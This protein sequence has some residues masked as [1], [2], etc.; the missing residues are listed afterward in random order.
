MQVTVTTVIRHL[1]ALLTEKMDEVVSLSN[2]RWYR[3]ERYNTRDQNQKRT[4]PH[5]AFSSVRQNIVFFFT[6]QCN[7]TTTTT[8]ANQ[9]SSVLSYHTSKYPPTSSSKSP[10]PPPSGYPSY[11]PL[12]MYWERGE[13]NC[14]LCEGCC[15]MLFKGENL[16]VDHV[17]L[18]LS[19]KI[20]EIVSKLA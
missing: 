1:V 18:L 11:G 7:H 12:R 2:F 6:W 8:V 16:G 10:P 3:L 15:N 13:F 17:L 14:I 4:P 19:A 20:E 5:A 9:S